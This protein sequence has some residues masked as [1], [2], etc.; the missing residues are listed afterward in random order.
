MMTQKNCLALLVLLTACV[1]VTFSQETAPV[2]RWQK[3]FGGDG[4]DAVSPAAGANYSEPYKVLRRDRD[5]GYIAGAT[6]T[7]NSNGDVSG[8][9]FSGSRQV[10]II[11]FDSALNIKWNKSFGGGGN[12]I[13]HAV[14]PTPDGGYI[15]IANSDSGNG[16]VTD[17]HGFTDIWVVK[18][19]RDGNIEWKKSYGG[20]GEETSND[21]IVLSDGYIIS[22]SSGS[23]DGDVTGNH[24]ATNIYLAD[25]WVLR[26]D[27]SG[28]IIWNKCYGKSGAVESGGS[29]RQTADGGF[30]VAGNACSDGGDVSGVHGN[31][32]VA[33]FWLLKLTSTGDIQWQKCLGGTR[34]EGIPHLEITGDGGYIV[35]GSTASFDGD[36]SGWHG[37]AADGWLVKLTATGQVQWQKCFGGSD[38]DGFNDMIIMPDGG[39][40]T[41]GWTSSK[42]GDITQWYGNSDYSVAKFSSSGNLVWQG[43]FG[44][45]GGYGGYSFPYGILA[46]TENEFLI[47]GNT[48]ATTGEVTGNHGQEDLW[49]IRADASNIIKGNVFVD[50]NANGI[51]DAGEASYSKLVISAQKDNTSSSTMP[52]ENGAFRIV[53]D[54]GTYITTA[55][56]FS[57]YFTAIP[58]SKTSVF[59]SYF[60][61]DS[62]DIALQ[63]IQ[64]S[65]DVAISLFAL[66]PARFGSSVTYQI[67]YENSGTESLAGGTIK[68]IKPQGLQFNSSLPAQS[69]VNGDT[70]LWNYTSLGVGQTASIQV[71]FG[72]QANLG[73]LLQTSVQIIPQEPV[74]NLFD[75]TAFLKQVVIGSYDPNDKQESNGGLINQQY[76]GDGKPLHY[77][78]RFQNTGTDTAFNVAV[79]DTLDAKLDWNTVE[80]IG[81][82]HHYNLQMTDG[83]KLS[84]AFNNI[85]LPDSNVNEPASHGFIAYSVKPKNTVT[86]GDIIN[87][88]AGI[89]FDYNLPVAT[90]RQQTVVMLSTLPVKLSQ[91]DGVLQEAVV[92]LNWKTATEQHNRTFEIERSTEGVRFVKIGEVQAHNILS[93][94]SYIFTDASPVPGN[95][96]YR[97]KMIDEDGQYS[98]SN[99]IVINLKKPADPVLTVYPNPAPNGVVSVNLQ[100]KIE[101]ACRLTLSDAGGRLVMTKNL[102]IIRSESYSTTVNLGGLQ[103]GTY[104]LAFVAGSKTFT[105]K[106]LLR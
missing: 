101:G 41:A 100:G 2:L 6:T 83:N 50:K 28:N 42:D 105:S 45:Q 1:N 7:S 91:F 67:Y 29:I 103:R 87:N 73:T 19:D 70:I 3:S 9:N 18:L 98:Y 57:P 31:N 69:S 39:Y 8:P 92:T 12:D 51:R 47:L 23:N 30:I 27:F 66:S 24:D 64:V 55:R 34:Y 78:I 46:S 43:S 80:I 90:N 22:G 94:A 85:L 95:N 49:L 82:S 13:L 99:I 93:G 20:T 106:I 75:D 63:P 16:Q 40:V 15:F 96:Y 74:L 10:W 32:G 25:L 68:M 48:D 11:K 72:Q 61:T 14:E 89:Y 88:G 71:D 38:A 53:T 81:A 86:M 79:R 37:G 84:W 76:I 102:G 44:G 26:I 21:I 65:H 35:A 52:D 36:V 59:S 104:V 58:A 54:S 33:D 17:N 60:N 62:F 4:S 5:G 77:M 56:P 97:L